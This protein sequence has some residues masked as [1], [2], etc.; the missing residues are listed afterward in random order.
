MAVSCT[1]IVRQF[2]YNLCSEAKTCACDSAL[3]VL[4]ALM[5]VGMG[6]MIGMFADYKIGEGVIL[7]GGL[8]LVTGLTINAAKGLYRAVA[9]ARQNAE[10]RLDHQE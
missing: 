3:T 2:G 1:D 8:S 5:V 6:S 7:G 9:N 4:N 10:E